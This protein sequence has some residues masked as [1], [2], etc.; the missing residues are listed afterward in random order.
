M[1]YAIRKRCH[2]FIGK[3]KQSLKIIPE[4]SRRDFEGVYGYKGLIAY[5]T[6][7]IRAVDD[8]SIFFDIK[9]SS[10]IPK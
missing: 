3:S 7:A 1:D 5:V 6:K 8:Y 10:I 2:K 9:N 4:D